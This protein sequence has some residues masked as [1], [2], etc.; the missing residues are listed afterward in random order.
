MNPFCEIA[1][2]EALRLKDAGVAKEVVV[3]SAGPASSAETLRTAL[4]MGADRALHIRAD[5]PQP[6]EPLA[7]AK[8]LAAVA[9]AERPALALLGKQSVD[10]DSNQTGQMLAGARCARAPSRRRARSFINRAT[11]EAAGAAPDDGDDAAE[12]AVC[13]VCPRPPPP[14]P[15]RRARP[16]RRTQACCPGRRPPSRRSWRSTRRGPR[17]R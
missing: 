16:A 6:L 17:R 9:R 7:V 14:P 8:L 4:A 3:V 11:P 15:A 12:A 10:G 5:G 1:L 13:V 2:E